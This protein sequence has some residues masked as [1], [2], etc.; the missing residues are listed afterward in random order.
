[1]KEENISEISLE[2]LKCIST[3]GG[4]IMHALKS[5]ED[6]YCGFGEAYFSWIEYNFIKAWKRHIKMTMNLIVPVGMIQFVFYEEKTHN[7]RSEKI[8]SDRY[9]RLTVPPGIWFGFK[10]LNKKENILL[11][12]ANIPHDPKEVEQ[13]DISSIEYNW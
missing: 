8:G 1:M 13:R 7:F 10:G 5:F 6:N 12:I 4:D 11:N 3:P 2:S 9:M